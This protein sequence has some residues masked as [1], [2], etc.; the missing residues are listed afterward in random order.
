MLKMARHC[1]LDW[2]IQILA[3]TYI[4]HGLERGVCVNPGSY[5]SP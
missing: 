5:L 4:A 2:G 1:D 3:K